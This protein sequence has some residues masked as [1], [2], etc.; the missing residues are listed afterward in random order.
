MFNFFSS[1]KISRVFLLSILFLTFIIFIVV[2]IFSTFIFNNSRVQLV[3]S[4][5]LQA[6]S[7]NKLIPE[8]DEVI[9]FDEYAD[10]LA[11]QDM[12]YNELRV[13]V[14]DNNWDVIG[15][16]LVDR[17]DLY[18]LEKHSPDTRVEIQEALNNTY[19]STSRRSESTG[20]D[21][22]YVAIQRDPNDI[23]QGLV[24]VALPFDIWESFFNFFIYPFLA[25]F[26]LVIASSSFL[27]L[28]VEYALRRDLDS[29]LKSTRKAIKGQNISELNSGDKQLSTLSDAVRQIANR[30]ND[31][32]EQAIEQRTEFGT[33]LDSM[34]QG[35]IIF[36]KNYK[37]RFSK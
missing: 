10:N 14:I 23:K 30:L 16:S 32:V 7:I 4:L 24:R 1:F 22:I 19:G 26:L 25:L 6:Q 5:Y 21:L 31:E 2:T 3:E 27:S 29:L 12:N 37:V 15:D 18:L 36:N 28:N 11:I 20:L 35:V 13:T 34:N 9:N 33:V 17:Q 8:Y